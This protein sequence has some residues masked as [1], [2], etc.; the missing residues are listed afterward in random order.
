MPRVDKSAYNDKHKGQAKYLEEDYVGYVGKIVSF[1]KPK[2]SAWA[3]ESKA[4]DDA[5]K[6]GA[7]RAQY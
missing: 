3:T 6:S 2:R 1:K 5:R 4:Y 7:A